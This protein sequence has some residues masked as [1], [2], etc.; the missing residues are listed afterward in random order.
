MTSAM[1][2]AVALLAGSSGARHPDIFAAR[3]RAADHDEFG[4]PTR[5]TGLMGSGR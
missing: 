5:C 1:A 2:A 3:Q 4:D